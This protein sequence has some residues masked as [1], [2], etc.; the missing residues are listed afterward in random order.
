MTVPTEQDFYKDAGVQVTDKRII[1]AGQTIVMNGVTAVS[2]H[3][4]VLPNAARV[5]FLAALAALFFVQGIEVKLLALLVIAPLIWIS[6]NPVY[7]L[8]LTSSSG[9][10]KVLGDRK[11]ERIFKISEAIN[12]A[13]IHRS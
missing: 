13:I 5:V 2:T 4:D 8:L 3:R 1:L 7:S 12:Q 6:L 10:N 9:S 11:K